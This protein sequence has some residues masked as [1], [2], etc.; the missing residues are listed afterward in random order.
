MLYYLLLKIVKYNLKCIVYYFCKYII[1]IILISYHIIEHNM[2]IH[3]YDFFF[4]FK[5]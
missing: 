4:K 3:K 5:F 2:N 1:I